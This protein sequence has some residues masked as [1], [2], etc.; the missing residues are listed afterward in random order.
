MRGHNNFEE[1][2]REALDIEEYVIGDSPKFSVQGTD[3]VVVFPMRP[4][5]P[6]EDSPF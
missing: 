1:L 6:G 2:L 3:A 4:Y 5:D